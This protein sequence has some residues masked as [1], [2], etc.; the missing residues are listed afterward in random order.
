MTASSSTSSSGLQF[1]HPYLAVVLGGGFT[2]MLAA[3]ALAGHADVIIVEREKLPRTPALPTDLPHA[4]HAHLLA[5]DGARLVDALLPGSLDGWLAEGARRVP[6][7]AELAVRSPQ[8]WLRRRRPPYLVA[9]SRDLLDRVARQRVTVLPGVSVLDGT[10]AEELTGTAEHVTGVRVRDTTTGATRR[11]DADLVVDATG[12]HSTTQDRLRALGLPTACEDLADCGI[13]SA[14]RLFR[15]PDGVENHPV[16]ISR[17]G[18]S[19]LIPGRAAPGTPARWLPD[20]TA[21]LVPVE[22]GRW[23]VTLTGTGDA[24]PTQHAGRFVPFARRTGDP[25]LADLLAGAEPLSEVRLSRSTV[26]RRR[27]FDRLPC[28]PSGFIALGGAVVSLSPDFGQGLSVAAHG[29]TAL[30]EAVR[31]HGLDDPALARKVQ[32]AIGSIAQEPWSVATGEAIGSP[33]A[34]RRAVCR[35]YA[36]VV[37]AAARTAPFVHSSAALNLLRDRAARVRPGADGAPGWEAAPIPVPPPSAATA[38]PPSAGAPRSPAAAG[39]PA[40]SALPAASRRFPRPLGFG[41]TA[42]R[43]IGGA[44][45]RKP[46]DD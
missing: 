28:W 20:R 42:L 22:G 24:R 45:R 9:C 16:L 30:R 38:G 2:G 13:V 5:A 32:R 7:P 44:H 11:L 25:A 17:S 1:T 40:L 19:G 26:N 27:R 6:V 34:G 29:A 14:T 12:R 39:A 37:T 23:L 36:D 41:P 18:S 3:A 31:R 10:E 8:G 15:A 46:A 43:R 35:A 4:R 33:A 21:T